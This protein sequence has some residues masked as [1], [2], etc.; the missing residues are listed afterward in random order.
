MTLYAFEFQYAGITIDAAQD[1]DGNVWISTP[2]IARILETSTDR[3]I[4]QVYASKS[5]KA[6]AGNDFVLAKFSSK[7]T[8]PNLEPE[9]LLDYCLD[10][11]A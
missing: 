1:V 4:G 3:R 11:Y 8:K 10:I 6:F 5:F 2:T 7:T 9:A